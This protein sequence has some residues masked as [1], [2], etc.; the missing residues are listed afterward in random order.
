[1]KAEIIIP[2]SIRRKAGFK[3]GE[4]VDLEVTHRRITIVPRFGPD[5]IEDEREINDSRI[6]SFIKKSREEFAAGKSRPIQEL[7]AER[8]R[9]KRTR[10][11][12]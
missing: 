5:E 3:D 9:R 11:K 12:A 2:K 6:R 1:M 4:Q 10:P 8:A 7:F